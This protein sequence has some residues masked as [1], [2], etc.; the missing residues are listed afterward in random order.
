[1]SAGSLRKLTHSLGG[2]RDDLQQSLPACLEIL[3]GAEPGDAVLDDVRADE[4][5]FIGVLACQANTD[6]DDES[7]MLLLQVILMSGDLVDG[8]F[9]MLADNNFF[10]EFVPLIYSPNDNIVL[11][12]CLLM[13]CMLNVRADLTP[14]AVSFL[15]SALIDRLYTILGEAGHETPTVEHAMRLLISCNMHYKTRFNNPVMTALAEHQYA[16]EA[17][18]LLI[19]VFNRNEVLEPCLKMLRDIFARSKTA[20]LLYTTDVR[21]LIDV[22]YRELGDLPERSPL[23]ADYVALLHQ[24]VRNSDYST[25]KYRGAELLAMLT[26]L[27]QLNDPSAPAAVS[28]LAECTQMLTSS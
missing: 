27:S 14:E 5:T 24:V 23:R 25:M 2:S 3:Q 10:R 13:T 16:K 26:Q 20:A 9:R 11:L 6:L 18:Q 15:D 4:Y 21:V 17:G 8:V 7:K 1:M 12:S 28:M 22:I 19:S